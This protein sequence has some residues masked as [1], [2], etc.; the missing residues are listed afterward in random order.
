MAESMKKL[1]ELDKE[2]RKEIKKL[3][4]E[5]SNLDGQKK[6]I[7]AEMERTPKTI[8]VQIPSKDNQYVTIPNPDYIALAEE[9][10]SV[11][12]KIASVRT[13]IISNKGRLERVHF[14]SGRLK[15]KIRGST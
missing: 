1:E 13:E 8:R 4:S 3:E 9:L 10:V 14:I 5:L 7:T 12:A 6:R 2:I 15:E 11:N